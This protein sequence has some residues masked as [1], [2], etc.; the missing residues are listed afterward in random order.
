MVAEALDYTLEG[1]KTET[2]GYTS[3]TRGERLVDKVLVEAERLVARVVHMLE[4]THHGICKPR[5]SSRTC[6]TAQH[7]ERH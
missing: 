1:A 7:M 5:H 3:Q 6:L 4:R 2:V